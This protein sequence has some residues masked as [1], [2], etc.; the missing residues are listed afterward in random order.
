M[1]VNRSLQ[2][3]DGR[4][5]DG[6]REGSLSTFDLQDS[7]RVRMC[8]ATKK[9]ARGQIGRQ[10][11]SL[12]QLDRSDDQTKFSF[13]ASSYASFRPTNSQTFYNTLL[14]YHHGPT[15]SLGHGLIARRLSPTFKHIV[16][17]DPSPSMIA[18]ARSSI[19]DSPEFSNIDFCQASAES[20]DDIPSGSVDAVMAGQ[21]W[22][23]AAW[24]AVLVRGPCR[25]QGAASE[26][27]AKSS[28]TEFSPSTYSCHRPRSLLVRGFSPPFSRDGIL[29]WG[30]AWR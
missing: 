14:R 15:T 4:G 19:V 12:S 29:H 25:R 27:L 17:T 10:F 21:A 16:A 5:R 11:S 7:Q 28:V 30:G 22:F 3:M 8:A 1:K 2:R 20:L 26:V 18:Q 6:L 24:P 9:G 13:S 23:G